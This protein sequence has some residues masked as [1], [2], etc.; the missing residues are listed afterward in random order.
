[1]NV[2]VLLC[3]KAIQHDQA[4]TLKTLVTL[5]PIIIMIN[6]FNMYFIVIQ[7]I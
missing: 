4:I 3:G 2:A 6:V 5:A 1:M 7:S